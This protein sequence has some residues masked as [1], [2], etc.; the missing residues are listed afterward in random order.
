M[1][2]MGIPCFL[3]HDNKS[4]VL[5]EVDKKR[6]NFHDL[7]WLAGMRDEDGNLSL[8]GMKK[9]SMECIMGNHN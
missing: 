7:E 2:I 1:I 5:I 8:E 3:L 9:L 4:G 6:Y